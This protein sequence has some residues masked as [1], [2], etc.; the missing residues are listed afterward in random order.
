LTTR[1]EIASS[2]TKKLPSTTSTGYPTPPVTPNGNLG[3]TQASPSSLNE[4]QTTSKQPDTTVSQTTSSSTTSYNIPTPP[5]TPGK[6]KAKR[7]AE[8]PVEKSFAC[9]EENGKFKNPADCTSYIVCVNNVPYKF[10]CN[11]DKY[12]DELN[13]NCDHQINL[14]C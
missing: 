3:T 14:K 9:P 4:I 12:Y 8:Y 10:Y 7:S 13:N 5:V 2:T 6:T 11:Y 1:T